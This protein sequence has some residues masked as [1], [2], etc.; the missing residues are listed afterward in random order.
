MCRL[1]RILPFLAT[2][3]TVG[4]SSRPTVSVVHTSLAKQDLRGKTI[5]VGGFSANDEAVYPGQVSEMEILSDAGQALRRR[6]KKS[7]IV[8]IEDA[9]AAIGQPPA[10]FAQSVPVILGRT[11]APA[12]VRN[13][14]SQGIDYLLWIDMTNNSVAHRDS[15][16]R[17]TT[18]EYPSCSCGTL[19]GSDSPCRSASGGSCCS[20]CGNSCSRGQELIAYHRSVTATRDLSASYTLLDTATGKAAWQTNSRHS[21][22]LAHT[23][24]SKSDFPPL[25]PTP[26]PPDESELM[27]KMSEA[28]LGRLPR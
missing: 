6:L 4:C 9:W 2:A 14:R 5:V 15:Q 22:S 11:L 23:L 26:L 12:Y 7:N 25:P 28:A 1:F 16:W 8:Q 13:A 27:T 24:S 19:S 10:K 21:R 17:T 18:T 20:S 3:L